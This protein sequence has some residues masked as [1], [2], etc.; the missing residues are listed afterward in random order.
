MEGIGS[1][2]GTD[3]VILFKN[4]R[5]V[6]DFEAAFD[7]AF[8]RTPLQDEYPEWPQATREA[9]ANG[10]LQEGMTKRQAYIIVGAPSRFERSERDGKRVEVWFPRQE[11]GLEMGFLDLSLG[12]D[13]IPLGAHVRRRQVDGLRDLRRPAGSRRLMSPRT[14]RRAGRRVVAALPIPQERSG[15]QPADHPT[16]SVSVSDFRTRPSANSARRPVLPRRFPARTSRCSGSSGRSTR[17]SA[18]GRGQR[19][20]ACSAACPRG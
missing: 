14:C 16:L 18:R 10:N 2:D 4:I 13:G 11:R 12:S 1:W 5:S 17:S 3:T 6:A 7:H 15:Q 8:A 9:I 20:L 19:A